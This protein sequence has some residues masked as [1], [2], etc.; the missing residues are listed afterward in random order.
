M[1]ESDYYTRRRAFDRENAARAEA[2]ARDIEESFQRMRELKPQKH[3]DSLAERRRLERENEAA[4]RRE[5]ELEMENNARVAAA[6][7]ARPPVEA[8]P[9][10]PPKPWVTNW[11]K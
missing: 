2:E 5:A 8:E 9:P 7:H 6:F 1:T 10:P 4:A 3:H 11:R